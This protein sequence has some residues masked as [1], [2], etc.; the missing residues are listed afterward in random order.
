MEK[1]K[2]KRM[3]LRKIIDD[4]QIKG[5]DSLA[6]LIKKCIWKGTRWKG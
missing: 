5:A 3:G 2:R 4:G 1:W 6:E